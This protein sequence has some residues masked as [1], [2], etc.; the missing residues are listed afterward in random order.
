MARPPW[1]GTPSLAV[2]RLVE[3]HGEAAR[4]LEVSDEP[5][6]VVLDRLRELDAVALQLGH[7]LLDVVAI[8]RDLRGARWRTPV[9]RM[10]AEVGLR[11]V[12]DQPAVADVGAFP[13]EAIADERAQRLR[14]AA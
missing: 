14:L 12:E 5:V 4:H 11:C 2:A 7:R 8:E 10:H 3:L 9:G 1:R 13:S 6:A